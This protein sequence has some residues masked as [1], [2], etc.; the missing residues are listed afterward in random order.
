MQARPMRKWI[1]A[2]A[3]ILVLCLATVVTLFG[4]RNKIRASVRHR[5]LRVLEAHFQ[6]QVQ[7]TGFEVSLFPRVRVTITEL[8]MQF[9]GRTDLPPLI[10]VRK[11]T[12]HANILGLIRVKPKIAFVVLEGLQI[13]MP[14]REPGTTPLIPETGEDLAKKDSVVV[15]ELQ[16]DDAVVVVL[17]AQRDKPSHELAIHHLEVHNLNFDRPA[18]FHAILTNALPAAGIDAT[19]QF[20]PWFAN[21]PSE[22]PAAGQYSFDHT[23]LGT[24]RDV[25][26]ILSS[27]GKFNGPLDYLTIEGEADIPNFR[28]RMGGPAFAVHTSYSALV[29]GAKGNTHLKSAT[30]QFLHTTLE[31]EGE[32]VDENREGKGRTNILNVK[33]EK[34]RVEDLLRLVVNSDPPEITGAATLKAKIEIPEGNADLLNRLKLDGQVGVINQKFSSQVVQDQVDT[35]SRKGQ[36]K[37]KDTD[38]DA[39]ESDWNGNIHVE[40]AVATFSNLS[41]HVTGA[42]IH[43]NGTYNVENGQLDFHGQLRLQAKLSQ[44]TT[45]AK[46]FFLKAIDPFFQG[47]NA[48]TVVPIK[49]TGTKDHPLFGPSVQGKD[50]KNAPAV[51]PETSKKDPPK[52]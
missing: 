46:S 18:D 41:F 25:E 27:R 28:L 50:T 3:A 35:L 44:T 39:A 20:G 5:T 26:G 6:S 15:E 23:D 47:Q 1:I 16:A 2:A 13:H 34:A 4:F 19:G 11:A 51:P 24:L 48:G 22:T 33:S 49:I 32:I 8:E 42:T 37:P 21:E 12:A 31:V 52:K 30:A 38:I 7:F 45:G 17:R 9:H 14:P 29:D 36:G 40:K 43:L 10:Q